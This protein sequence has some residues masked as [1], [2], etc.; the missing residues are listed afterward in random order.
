MGSLDHFFPAG[1]W[2]CKHSAVI[3]IAPKL[4]EPQAPGRQKCGGWNK[5][6]ETAKNYH[7]TKREGCG[8]GK[9]QKAK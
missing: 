9:S 7:E 5:I 4:G 2:F 3:S 1:N 8:N 6:R